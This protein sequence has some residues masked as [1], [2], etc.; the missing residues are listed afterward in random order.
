MVEGE[1]EDSVATME[2]ALVEVI[3]EEDLVRTVEV[4]SMIMEVDMVE[5]VVVDIMMIWAETRDTAQAW[6]EAEV[7]VQVEE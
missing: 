3:V 1:E 4:G 7:Q 5:E 6:E 2:E